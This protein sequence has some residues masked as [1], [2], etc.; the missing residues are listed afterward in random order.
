MQGSEVR[1]DKLFDR[2]CKSRLFI[3]LSLSAEIYYSVYTS[4]YN[5][6]LILHFIIGESLPL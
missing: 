4:N 3:Y 6:T 1:F 5:N 2:I